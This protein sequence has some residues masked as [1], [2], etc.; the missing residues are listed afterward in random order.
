MLFSTCVHTLLHTFSSLCHTLLHL[1]AYSA[2][3]C[4]PVQFFSSQC[5]TFLHCVCV[6]R[7]WL[8]LF[9]TVAQLFLHCVCRAGQWHPCQ[10]FPCCE[11]RVNARPRSVLP[12]HPRSA[13]YPVYTCQSGLSSSSGQPPC[14]PRSAPL[15]PPRSAPYPV[16]K[17]PPRSSLVSPSRFPLGQRSATQPRLGHPKWS[18]LFFRSASCPPG[19][20]SVFLSH[21]SC[22]KSDL[23]CTLLHL[24]FG[25]DLVESSEYAVC[26][27]KYLLMVWVTSQK[28]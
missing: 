12:C 22:P 21:N 5:D 11:R 26:R 24:M 15:V 23:N 3:Q 13:P 10:D 6:C 7:T 28:N 18:E 8:W 17:C 14:P 16:S 25:S 20:S 19:I 2:A 1:C 9:S 4:T 27:R